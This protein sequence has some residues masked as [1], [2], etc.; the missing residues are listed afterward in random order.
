MLSDI[1]SGGISP[2]T[3]LPDYTGKLYKLSDLHGDDPLILTT[4][5]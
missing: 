1:L 5:L 2:T 4:S 3:E